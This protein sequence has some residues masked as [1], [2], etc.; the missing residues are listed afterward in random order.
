MWRQGV[1]VVVIAMAVAGDG[2]GCDESGC[3]WHCSQP[4]TDL[5]GGHGQYI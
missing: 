4:H 1:G 5:E 3:V 2:G